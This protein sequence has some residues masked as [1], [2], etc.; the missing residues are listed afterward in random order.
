MSVAD[1]IGAGEV[2]EAVRAPMALEGSPMGGFLRN[3]IEAL[4]GAELADQLDAGAVLELLERAYVAGL[5]EGA[6]R[7]ADLV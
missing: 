7:L 3:R 1:A 4:V 6:L 2:R 5:K